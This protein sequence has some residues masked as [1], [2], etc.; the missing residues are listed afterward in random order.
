VC[1]RLLQVLQELGLRLENGVVRRPLDGTRYQGQMLAMADPLDRRQL[2]D[3]G[4]PRAGQTGQTWV[5]RQHG[6]TQ[7]EAW[8][9]AWPPQVGPIPVRAAHRELQWRP[10]RGGQQVREQLSGHGQRI[11]QSGDVYEGESSESAEVLVRNDG[12]YCGEVSMDGREPH[13][14]GRWAELGS[15]PI[16]GRW[17]RGQRVRSVAEGQVGLLAPRRP[18]GRMQYADGAHPRLLRH[19]YAGC[20]PQEATPL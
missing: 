10:R 4:G 11:Y 7:P 17:E 8:V 15:E 20:W 13:G 18:K 2:E 19:A 9:G 14:Y 3:D 16:S 1:V 5:A 6:Q 12:V